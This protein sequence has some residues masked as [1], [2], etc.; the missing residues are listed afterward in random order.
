MAN[1]RKMRFSSFYRA[2]RWGKGIIFRMKRTLL[3]TSLF[4]TLFILGAFALSVNAAPA[5]QLPQYATPTP[6]ADGKIIY[7]V[8]EGDSC[9]RIELLTGISVDQLRALNQLDEN[10]TL[11][12]G[13]QLVIGM[14]SP[15]GITPTADPSQPTTIP[16]TPTPLPSAGHAKVCISLYDDVNGDAIPQAAEG[17]IPGGKASITGAMNPFSGS[18]DTEGGTTPSCFEEVPE[19]TYTMSVAAPAGYAPTTEQ[20]AIL[21]V[22]AGQQI[23]VMF[24][25]Q[26]LA[27]PVSE[28]PTEGLGLMGLVGIFGV[29]LVVVALAMGG[30][31][32]YAYLRNPN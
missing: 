1:P 5:S 21:E 31:Y 11:T 29:I 32:W 17:I 3:L 18:K 2:K 14:G 22:K 25:A 26:K 27:E 10:C 13:Q 9:L 28:E 20:A 6:N 12:P 24:G 30:Y 7:L 16:A 23:Q 15:S 19:G 8:A 4:V